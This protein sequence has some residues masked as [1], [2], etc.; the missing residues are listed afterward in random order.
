MLVQFTKISV[1][2]FTSEIKKQLIWVLEDDI[3]IIREEIDKDESDICY[4]IGTSML[5]LKSGE[6]HYILTPSKENQTLL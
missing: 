4:N 5:Y 6:S 3:K 2:K 1:N